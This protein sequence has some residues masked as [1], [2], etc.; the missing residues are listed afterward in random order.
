MYCIYKHDRPKLEPPF[1]LPRIPRGNIMLL[2]TRHTGAGVTL[3][4]VNSLPDRDDICARILIVDNKCGC[5][6]DGVDESTNDLYKNFAIPT[7]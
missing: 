2:Q 7:K 3:F 1:V 5:D 4:N 6:V